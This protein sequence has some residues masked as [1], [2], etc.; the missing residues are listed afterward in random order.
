MGLVQNRIVVK[1]GTSSLTNDA[2]NTNLRAFDKISMV[3]IYI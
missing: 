1:V 2:G 3:L